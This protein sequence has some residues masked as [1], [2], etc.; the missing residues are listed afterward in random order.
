MI[1]QL[2]AS[3]LFVSLLSPVSLAQGGAVKP[4]SAQAVVTYLGEI[5]GPSMSGEAS[6]AE[7]AVQKGFSPSAYRQK[8]A[9][10]LTPDAQAWD[11][12]ARDGRVLLYGY[13]PEGRNCGL[14]VMNAMP[15]AVREAVARELQ[16]APDAYQVIQTSDMGKGAI[17]TRLQS[18]TTGRYV[19]VIDYSKS[20]LLKV[21]LLP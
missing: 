11:V 16:G 2:L 12:P 5:C 4:F 8:A 15:D 10:I 6:V 18:A 13:G 21:E 19:D 3:L 20:A 1:R 9:W 14:I 17:F 7:L